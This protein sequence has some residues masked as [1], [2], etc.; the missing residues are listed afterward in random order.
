LWLHL[1]HDGRGGMAGWRF[2]LG[3][4]NRWVARRLLSLETAL[5][6][7][8]ILTAMAIR[9]QDELTTD[10]VTLDEA[11]AAT[12]YYSYA[13]ND[14]PSGGTS[15]VEELRVLEWRC[16]L[17]NTSAHPHC[18][19]G[20]KFDT[21]K[22]NTG[23]KL[24]G[25]E[26]IKL[27]LD[28]TG[29]AEFLRI[30]LK[31]HRARYAKV[32]PHAAG[33]VSQTTIAV[34]AGNQS[35]QAS[36][37]DF[38]VAEW[39]R[40]QANLPSN[41]MRPEFD[42][43]TA[44][45][46]VTGNDPRAGV[47]QIKL[48]KITFE[49]RLITTQAWYAGIAAVWA[50]LISFFLLSRRKHE[51]RQRQQLATMTLNSVPEIIWSVGADGFPDYVSRQWTEIYGGDPEALVGRGWIRHIHP[52][53]LRHALNGWARATR[54]LQPFE[55]ELRAKLPDGSY[56]WVLARARPELDEHGRIHR[57][58]GTCTD[59]HERVVAVEALK[60]SER[61]HRGFLEASADCICILSTDG[62][63]EFANG[64]GL[65]AAEIDSLDAIKG[66][67]WTQFWQRKSGPMI[68]GA[69]ARA[70]AGDTVRFRSFCPT[71]KGTPR[72]WDVV[73]TPM[74]DETGAVKGLL[75]I[76]RD[77]TSDREKSEQLKWASE[78]DALTS[79][80]NRRAFQSRLQAATLR[81]MITGENLG[82]MLIDLDH[83]K[84]VNDSLGHSAGD[85][86]LGTVAER[87]G[88]AVRD[89]D[90][91]A[92]VGGDEFAV[93][94]ENVRSKE[95]AL[96][97]G[98]KLFTALQDPVQIGGRMISA[99]ASI[100]GAMFPQ[101]AQSAN[102]LF[103]NADTA[104]YA[105]KGSGRGGTM[106]FD[107]YMLEGVEKAA[108]QLGRARN[109]ISEKNVLPVYQPQVEVQTGRIVGFE[110]LLRWRHPLK[111]LQL[112]AT[113][114][115]AFK[116]YEL[117][118]KIGELM[119]RRVA[120]DVRSWMDRGLVFGRVSINA[121]PAEFLRDDYAERLLT[122]LEEQRVP[123]QM[124]DIEVTEHALLEL[125]PEYVARAL[126][127]LKAAGVTV[128]LDDFGTGYSSLSHLR[129]FPVDQVKI[130]MSFVQQMS[131]DEEIA[132]IVAAVV[133]LARSISIQVVA[134]GVETPAQL[135]LLKIMGCHFAQGHLFGKA[136]EEE[137]VVRLLTAAAAAAA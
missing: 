59:A 25:Y 26:S 93:I 42:N 55:A 105:L 11:G 97:L 2:T 52:A 20:L 91:V 116:D 7:A 8:V 77:V 137:E 14:A 92:R 131:E 22:T 132:S 13:Y 82:L 56:R 72:W 78:H 95:D 121:A 85:E 51:A 115:E 17:S 48:R 80:P 127:L 47:H 107:R 69:L 90:F 4:A 35:V 12:R 31:N 126:A 74:P 112:P 75:A 96:A 60:A 34:G 61:L 130:D 106:L 62:L 118:T 54:K 125:G 94:L 88:A 100:G 83:F 123:P 65:K 111:G 122:V 21:D 114:Q 70:R 133:N 109:A 99:G 36:L 119:Q 128:S 50:I 3:I 6:L 129:D 5:L 135:D 9:C 33:Q 10:R 32:A 102:D 63:I 66:K 29:R 15:K 113:V 49:R 79:L 19:Y 16:T 41:E 23:L 57:W 104:L 84:H 43:V 98:R 110:A 27:D 40:E 18:G 28:Y 38:V 120:I 136:V 53:D 39:W 64:P 124:I 87:L 46:F 67:H 45:E 86:V 68:T 108:S 103:K 81:A 24:N 73:L 30:I 71:A 76:C 101:D 89:T 1:R 134:E 37:S 117:A 44:I 58:Y